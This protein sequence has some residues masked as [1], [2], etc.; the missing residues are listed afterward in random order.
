VLMMP[1]ICNKQAKQGDRRSVANC[2]ETPWL[3]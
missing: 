1:N 3:L 2:M